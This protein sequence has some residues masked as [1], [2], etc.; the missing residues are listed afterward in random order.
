MI[1]SYYRC[2]DCG[3]EAEYHLSS[4][5]VHPSCFNCEGD[6]MERLPGR[7]N[8]GGIFMR[9]ATNEDLFSPIRCLQVVS[10]VAEMEEGDKKPF[11][12]IRPFKIQGGPSL[13]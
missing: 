8:I 13:N 7:F 11:V 5:D 3:Y 9:K 6:N 12:G 10:G 1:T 2:R 4:L